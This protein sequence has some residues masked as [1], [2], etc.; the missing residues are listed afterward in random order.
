MHQLQLVQVLIARFH[1]STLQARCHS[2]NYVLL[3]RKQIQVAPVDSLGQYLSTSLAAFEDAA[4][5]LPFSFSTASPKVP[6]HAATCIALPMPVRA[7][8]P[9]ASPSSDFS[10]PS[11]DPSPLQ[12]LV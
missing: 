9:C 4:Q 2:F 1:S 6:L 7:S 8:S 11:P 5:K 3:Q 10:V 12:I